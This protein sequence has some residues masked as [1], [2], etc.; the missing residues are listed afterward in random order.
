MGC[1]G[2]K[3]FMS[4]TAPRTRLW[5]AL[6]IV[7]YLVLG[8]AMSVQV[9][10]AEA[11]DELD[12]FLYTRYLAEERA[13]PPLSPIAVEN[14]TMEANQPPLYYALGALAVG[15]IDMSEPLELAQNACFSFDPDD[16]GRQTFYVHSTAEA[17]PYAETVLAFHLVRLLSLLLGATTVWLTFYLA[18]LI[19]PANEQAALLAAALLAFNPQF[20]FITASANNDVLAATIGTAIVLV[21]V[22]S[23]QRP[24]PVIFLLLGLVVGLG[25]LTKAGLLAL[26]PVALLAAMAPIVQRLFSAGEASDSWSR[27]LRDCLLPLALVLGLPL[28]VAGWWYGR[29]ALLYGDP[30]A[31]RVH[32]AAKGPFVL[33]EGSLGLEDLGEFA[34]L[35]FRSY[36]ALFGWLNVAVPDW[37]YWLLGLMVTMAVLGLIWSILACLRRDRR[38]ESDCFF[39]PPALG[40]G[41]LAI[42]ATYVSLLRYIQ[43]INWSGYQGRLAYAVAGVV[44][45]V[46][47]AGLA[48][49]LGRVKS[50]RISQLMLW[51]APVFLL[52]LSAASLLFL[53]REAYPQPGIYQPVGL[54]PTCAR[55]NNG[56]LLDGFSAPE[57][58]RPGQSLQ[59]DLAGFGMQANPGDGILAAELRGDGGELWGTVET[60][61]SW[62]PGETIVTSLQLPISPEAAP[63][64]ATLFIGLRHNSGS[65]QAATSANGRGLQLP[66]ALTTIKIP[67]PP[68]GAGRPQTA[69]TADLGGQ[70]RLLGYNLERDGDTSTVTLF[71]QALTP[72]NEDFTTFVH[73]LGADG[74][75]LAQADGQP[76]DGQ[77]PTA[78]WDVGEIVR[79]PRV[80]ILPAGSAEGPLT[81][82]AGAYRLPGSERLISQDGADSIPL[83]AF[84][85]LSEL[86][87]GGELR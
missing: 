35:H 74:Q 8:L 27:T 23:W 32:L 11:P 19:V 37:V 57:R 63:G 40:L 2:E 1:G 20:I 41:L 46:L 50:H 52:F 82:V 18:R 51:A 36:W 71:W 83:A 80:L 58:V 13:F 59:V 15:W 7:T 42:L 38:Q 22:I 44:V 3:E 28:L 6:I 29:A 73:L 5:L 43:T 48:F 30:L 68:G 69:V 21:S 67:Q 87:N 31:W 64:R 9:P 86:G 34:S 60:A 16:P 45:V 26:W 12:H 84:N 78:I 75:L 25:A 10:L 61:I 85:S 62:Q 49:L 47:A 17:W 77:Y 53:L 72:M 70:L 56:L 65:W 55:F 14:P 66:L 81:L 76:W 39:N 79:D 33:R 24:R 54:A 4:D